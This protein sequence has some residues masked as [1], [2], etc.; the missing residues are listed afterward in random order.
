MVV[1]LVDGPPG[2]LGVDVRR[3]ADLF[4]VGPR[5]LLAVLGVLAND[6]SGA[7]GS[8]LVTPVRYA[9]GFASPL[10][11]A[12]GGILVS[13]VRGTVLCKRGYRPKHYQTQ[14]YPH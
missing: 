3:V 4:E 11:N 7:G 13:R 2:L 14:P 8:S 9:S 6:S 10:L 1:P 12:V 5:A